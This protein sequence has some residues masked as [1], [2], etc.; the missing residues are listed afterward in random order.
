MISSGLC[1]LLGLRRPFRGSG[2]HSLWATRPGADH[3]FEKT[4]H[5]RIFT[6]S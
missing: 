3:A 4:G 2:Y 1:F 6:I 5:A